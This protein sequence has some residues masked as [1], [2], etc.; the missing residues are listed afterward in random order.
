MED[1]LSKTLYNKS[2][3]Q[4]LKL[5]ALSVPGSC[6]IYRTVVCANGAKIRT[7]APLANPGIITQSHE[8]ET[9]HRHDRILA[10]LQEAGALKD[11]L[12]SART[13][14]GRTESVA[15]H[16]WSLCL[17]VLL[18]EPEL[19]GIDVLKLMRLC[20]VHDLGEAISGDVP[21]TEQTSD[22]GKTDRERADVATL[23]AA[24]PDDLRAAIRDLWEEYEAGETPEAR[25][26]KG[27]DKLETMLQHVAG[28]QVPGFDYLWNLDYGRDRTDATPLLSDLRDRV[29]A[30]TRAAARRH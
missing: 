6:A 5:D 2:L 21:A 25:L 4:I 15:E 8:M 19:D 22:D 7:N 11:T 17:L 18:L 29:D 28:N 9:P 27:F 20:L 10:F 16:S 24:L 23:T 3:R 13:R 1:E 12:R 14:E 30:L 26:A